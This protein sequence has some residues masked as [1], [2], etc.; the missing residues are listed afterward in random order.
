MMLN[1]SKRTSMAHYA[2]K[3]RETVAAWTCAPGC[4]VMALDAQSG[5]LHSQNPATRKGRVGKHGTG[6]G[7]TYFGVKET[8]NHYGDAGGASRF[9]RQVGGKGE[10]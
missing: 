5:V 3:G 9:F 7:T 1:G 10:P 2:T 4:P 6:D 8:G